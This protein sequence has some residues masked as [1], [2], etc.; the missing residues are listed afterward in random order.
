M[1]NVPAHIHRYLVE[2]CSGAVSVEWTVLTFLLVSGMGTTLSTLGAAVHGIA[3][4]VT[5]E[6][7]SGGVNPFGNVENGTGGGCMSIGSTS[8]C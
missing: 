8:D 7:H 2:D 6:I 5:A 3:N 4:A 1:R